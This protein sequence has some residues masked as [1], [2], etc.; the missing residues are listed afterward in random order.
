MSQIAE[1]PF[2]FSWSWSNI[3]LPTTWVPE[4]V[5]SA[6][7]GHARVESAGHYVWF[8][9]LNSLPKKKKNIIQLW[10]K[11]AF[12][13]I[14]GKGVWKQVAYQSYQC[15]RHIVCFILRLADFTSSME[16]VCYGICCHAFS[17]DSYFFSICNMKYFF[18]Q[19]LASCRQT[20]DWCRQIVGR[21]T[22][23]LDK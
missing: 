16:F 17:Y 13:D 3:Y 8:T 18:S 19:F 21:C 2:F 15:C 4:Y 23:N 14:A 6:L 7:C 22:S 12:T 9:S 5:P 20:V 10:R 1:T 11:T